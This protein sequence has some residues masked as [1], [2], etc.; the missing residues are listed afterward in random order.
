MTGRIEERVS[1]LEDRMLTVEA[2]LALVSQLQVANAQQLNSLTGKVDQISSRVD[3]F[4]AE[5]QRL[6]TRIGGTAEKNEAAV[7]SLR[8]SVTILARKGE[9][10]R[11]VAQSTTERM[12]SMISRLDALVNHLMSSDKG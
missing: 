9:E 6:F 10:D 11:K 3:S 8:Q 5:A 4:M 2:N 1:G 12:D 7:D